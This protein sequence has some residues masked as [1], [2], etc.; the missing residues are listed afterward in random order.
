LT[1]TFL[2]ILHFAIKN[3]GRKGAHE[4]TIFLCMYV[5]KTVA[6]FELSKR[7]TIYMYIYLFN[8]QRNVLNFPLQRLKN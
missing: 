2:N 1:E 6:T 4:K 3:Y 5:C 8:N 7:N